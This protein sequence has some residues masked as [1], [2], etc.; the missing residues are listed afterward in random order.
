MESL[1]ELLLNNRTLSG[2]GMKLVRSR[3]EERFVSY[4]ELYDRALKVLYRLQFSGLAQGDEL[5]LQI[6][7]EEH[8]LYIFWA[9]IAGGIIPVPVS[10]GGNDEHRLKLYKIHENLANPYL[11]IEQRWMT[12][13]EENETPGYSLSVLETRSLYVEDL[14]EGLDY[15]LPY[16]KLAS[17]NRADMAF[18]Q[19]SS[20]ST[21]TPKGVMLTHDNLLCNTEA[22]ANRLA[23][24]Q[25]D[26]FYSWMP[27]T[28]DMGMIAFHLTPFLSQINHSIMSTN[29]LIK[30]PALWMIKAQ[31]HGATVLGS[32]NFG[33]KL[34]LT[35]YKPKVAEGWD[36]SKIRVILNGAEPIS[37]ELCHRFVQ[38][39]GAYGLPNTAIL[40]AY[41]LAEGSVGVSIK[42][43][44]EPLHGICIDRRIVGIGEQIQEITD[45]SQHAVVFAEVGYPIDYVSIRISNEKSEKLPERVIGQIQ[46]KGRS[47]T[48]GYYRNEAATKKAVLQDGWLDTGDLG[49][50]SEGRLYVTGRMK[51][52]IFVNGKNYYPHDIERISEG[53]EGVELGKVAVVGLHNREEQ[54]EDIVVFVQYKRKVEQFAEIVVQLKKVINLKIGIEPA[55]VLP[56][57]SIPKT[58]SG[59]VQ[60]YQLAEMLVNGEFDTLIAEVNSH[61][62]K[63]T[64][65]IQIAGPR[66]EIEQALLKLWCELLNTERIGIHDNFFE[67]GGSSSC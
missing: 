22:I 63:Q 17:P 2:K 40:N 10:T 64:S 66:N 19:F 61:V 31:E 16:G 55:L 38:E 57:R 14:V 34:L 51:D 50:M 53:V 35:A 59:K 33:Y 15:H 54:R 32:P 18:I 4:E 28:H 12:K 30:S 37:I 60:R 42:N 8:F 49:F 13:L 29:A 58:T 47:V 11:A 3:Q 45:E 62:A 1:V 24:T 6:D 56:I 67:I 5:I 27:L 23:V 21:G 26:I 7:D 48:S 39:M 25:Q 46:I 43:P 20:G 65:S 52:I 36:L 44:D 9:C 41:G